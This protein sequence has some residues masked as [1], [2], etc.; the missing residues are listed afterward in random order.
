MEVL[1]IKHNAPHTYIGYPGGYVPNPLI[2]ETIMENHCIS[3]DLKNQPKLN[4]LESTRYYK[5]ELAAPGFKRENILVSIDEKCTLTVTAMHT[6]E[7]R[8]QKQ[9]FQKQKLND[10]CLSSEIALPK[11][12]DTDFVNAEYKSGILSIWF[13][14]IKGSYRHR[15][16]MIIVY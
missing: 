15:A 9:K 3:D 6:D 12:I 4:I 5:A 2:F 7:E 14:K 13:L 10:V 1:S 16:S 8:K 11:N